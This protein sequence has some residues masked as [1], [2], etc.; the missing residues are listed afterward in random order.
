MQMLVTNILKPVWL[1]NWLSAKG[2]VKGYFC[3]S[4]D[5]AANP[6][7][8][9]G[10]SKRLMEHIIFSSH[11]F[12]PFSARVTSA[13]FANVAFSDGSLLYSWIRRLEKCQPLAV[14]V[15][16][17]RFFISQREAGELCLLAAVSAP[18]Q[19][20]LI[21]RMNPDTDL[22]D[23][24]DIARSFLHTHGYEPFLCES[25]DEAKR[26]IAPALSQG[27]YPLLLT[28]LDTSGE[29]SFEEFVG[30]NEHIKE[31]GMNQLLAVEYLPTSPDAVK[32]FLTTLKR[33]LT[34]SNLLSKEDIIKMISSVVPELE[35][36]ES[37]KNLDQRM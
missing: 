13:R 3:V 20:L 17:R 9:M 37:G 10:A 2:S 26:Q 36:V 21:P 5:K 24:Q 4:T 31:I 27:K 19:H 23:L 12:C 11:E 30:N 22:H 35:H 16:T 7:N 28:P 25:E 32:A 14:P 8:L 6:V 34:E 1:M 33:A 18:H 29:K 15:N